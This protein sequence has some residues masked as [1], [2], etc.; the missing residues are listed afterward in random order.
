M[1]KVFFGCLWFFAIALIST[2]TCV[3][4]AQ[5]REGLTLL[6]NI[7]AQYNRSAIIR[8]LSDNTYRGEA[9]V[10]R[11]RPEVAR[12]FGLE[13][14]M[15]ENY[16]R[17]AE[18][19]TQAED[20]YR[21]LL[22]GLKKKAPKGLKPHG[23]NKLLRLATS[24][25]S[26]KTQATKLFL[27]Y[28]KALESDQDE[29]LVDSV[30]LKL[31]RKE[32][33]RSLLRY[34]NKL[35]DSLADFFNRTYRGTEIDPPLAP[36]NVD[37]V[38]TVFQKFLEKAPSRVLRNYDLDAFLLK[39]NSVRPEV[40]KMLFP[41]RLRSYGQIVERLYYKMGPGSYSVH[42]VLFMALMRRE[43][44]FDPTAISDVGAVG[45]TQIMPGTA[46]LL[47]M[48]SV[49]L[50]PYFREA[51]ELLRQARQWRAKALDL[52]EGIDGGDGRHKILKAWRYMQNA[53]R[54]AARSNKLFEKYEKDL[55]RDRSDDRFDV[56]KAISHG[57]KYFARMLRKYKGDI[58]LALAAYN[59]GPSRVKKYGGIPPFPET[60]TFRNAVLKYYEEYLDRLDIRPRSCLSKNRF[61][62]PAGE[63]DVPVAA[64]FWP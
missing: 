59:A 25:H 43:S 33:K 45:L 17:A 39:A 14:K 41:P 56:E 42:P 11:M 52:V 51:G 2:D 57:Y 18:L 13:A 21:E 46:K 28:Y 55:L 36:S 34:H 44:N 10:L 19:T 58:S 60:V 53:E 3:P 4:K 16:K 5:A 12:D 50:P 23:V 29:R 22:E 9:G 63:R 37:F 38:N 27:V 40:W 7:I 32:L 35:R 48:N 20:T 15:D 61:W 49:Y 64:S 8:S 31:L 30:C 1:R 26:K 62:V 47:G 24:Y 54:L 6:S